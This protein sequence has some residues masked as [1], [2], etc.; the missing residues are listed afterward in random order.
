MLFGIRFEGM[1]MKF[2]HFPFADGLEKYWNPNLLTLVAL[3]L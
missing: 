2:N 1:V 3:R